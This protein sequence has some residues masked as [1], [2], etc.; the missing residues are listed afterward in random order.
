MGGSTGCGGAA[1][2]KAD[3]RRSRELRPNVPIRTHEERLRDDVSHDRR[4]FH[5]LVLHTRRRNES[6]GRR[7]HVHQLFRQLRFTH[8]A[9]RRDVLEND[10]GQFNNLLGNRHKRIDELLSTS[11][12]VQ[13]L[14]TVQSR[15]FERTSVRHG[16]RISHQS[17]SEIENVNQ[18]INGVCWSMW[19]TL[20]NLLRETVK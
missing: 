3:P 19:L 5:Q 2:P 12:L 9:S 16:P 18:V 11:M 14:K 15:R 6:R 8:R 13:W 7:R 17:Q 20:D 1:P 4:H 10:L